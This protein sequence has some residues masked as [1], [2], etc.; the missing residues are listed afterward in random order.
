MTENILLNENRDVMNDVALYSESYLREIT[1]R[2]RQSAK[3]EVLQISFSRYVYDTDKPADTVSGKHPL[4]E[5]SA[6]HV[7]LNANTTVA[8]SIITETATD[9]NSLFTGSARENTNITVEEQ[10]A[11]E[12]KWKDW[13]KAGIGLIV[14]LFIVLAICLTAKFKK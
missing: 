3:S 6:V 8:D 9:E 2:I 14:V 11:T 1:N 12:P 7:T 13:E 5:E 10:I 4:K